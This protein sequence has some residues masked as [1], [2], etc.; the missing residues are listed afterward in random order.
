MPRI[1]LEKKELQKRAAL[2]LEKNDV[3]EVYYSED[4]FAFTDKDKCYAYCG[5][6]RI[7]EY[8]FKSKT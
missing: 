1:K 7:Q 4:G 2:F 6:A 3:K 8:T 5:A